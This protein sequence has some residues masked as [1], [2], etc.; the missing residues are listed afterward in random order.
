VRI[1]S[2]LFLFVSVLAFVYGMVHYAGLRQG[3][4]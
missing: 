4:R 2:K 3:W 1:K